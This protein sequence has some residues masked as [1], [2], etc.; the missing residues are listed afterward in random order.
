MKRRRSHWAWGWE[1]K[2]PSVEARKE[3]GEILHTVLKITPGELKEAVLL[4]DVKLRP[5]A[6]SGG[7]VDTT[8]E[9]RIRHTYGRSWPDLMRGFLGDFSAAPD[10]VVIVDSVADVQNVFLWAEKHDAAIQI[11]GGGTSV[12]GGVEAEKGRPTLSL[13]TS[14]L[15]GVHHI[16][17]VSRVARIGGGSF[18]PDIESALRPFHLTLRHFPQSFEFS[19]LGG[20]IATRSG[21]HYA[22]VRTHID[23][24]V[25]S[26]QMV[27]PSGVYETRR[28]PASGAGPDPNRL[29]CG[30]E[31]TLGVITQAWMRL[32][33]RPHFKAQ[34]SV[35]FRDWSGAVA[36]LRELGQSGLNPA[37]CRLLDSREALLNQVTFD[38]THVLILSFESHDSEQVFV[39]ERALDI[40]KAHKGECPTG[41]CYRDTFNEQASDRWRSAFLDGPYMQSALLTM[42]VFADTFETAVLWSDFDAFHQGVIQ[43]LRRILKEVCGSGFVTCR[44]THVYPDGLAPYYTW[45][46]PMPVRDVS[47]IEVW[48]RIKDAAMDA[49]VDLGGTISHHHA[50]G[51]IHREHYHREASPLFLQSL[52]AVKNQLDPHG[53]LNP[54]VL[55]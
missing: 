24:F 51:R 46:A 11:Y 31:G 3:L 12:V 44:I 21:G 49:V 27:T 28:L 16:D 38:G 22:T 34:A 10:G 2:I 37:N 32:Q 18:G 33:M 25:E 20:W 13:D 41:P 29:I 6:F 8:D 36:A 54:G 1:E 40:C 23:E 42:G 45:I 26:V 55:L 9:A 43:R 53:I 47:A 48:Q 19:T 7:E 52:R 50:V 4:Q 15:S 39:M 35:H 17:H 30:S 5:S 14:G